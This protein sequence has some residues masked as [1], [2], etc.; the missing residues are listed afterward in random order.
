MSLFIQV[1]ER[2]RNLDS[3]ILQSGKFNDALKNLIDWMKETEDLV[4]N[5]KPPSPD[6]KVAK[7][8][9]QEQKVRTRVLFI[10]S[11]FRSSLVHGSNA[12]NGDPIRIVKARLWM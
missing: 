12:L 1:S 8:Q 11:W 4:A 7:A 6:Y 5:Q 3:A 2:D 9:L 10:L